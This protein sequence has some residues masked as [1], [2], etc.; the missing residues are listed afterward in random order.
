MTT[1]LDAD[2]R[3]LEEALQRVRSATTGAAA[4]H[5]VTWLQG[6]AGNMDRVQRV[7]D[8]LKRLQATAA[9][10]HWLCAHL[11]QIHVET[12]QPAGSPEDSPM[13]VTLMQVWPEL[14]RTDAASADVAVGEA[15]K[16]GA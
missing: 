8:G 16:E 14:P 11:T 7:V 15:M 6:V 9:R 10:Y 13:R 2:V 5:A 12:T 4:A 3:A 1:D